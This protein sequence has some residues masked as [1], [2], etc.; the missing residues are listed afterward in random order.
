MSLNVILFIQTNLK[1]LAI[2]KLK[3]Y[4][5]I[6]QNP[7]QTRNLFAYISVINSWFKSQELK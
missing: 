3:A 6:N 5:Y 4:I 2:R 1:V 7:N